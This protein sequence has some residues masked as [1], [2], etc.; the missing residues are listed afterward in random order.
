MINS[1]KVTVLPRES[2]HRIET[3]PIQIGDDWPGVF[4]RGDQALFF[5]Y[6]LEGSVLPHINEEHQLQISAIKGLIKTLKSCKVTPDK[7]G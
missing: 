4:I 1:V 3:G 7:Q 2:E 5:A 6:L